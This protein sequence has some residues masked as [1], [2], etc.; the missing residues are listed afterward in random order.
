MEAQEDDFKLSVLQKLRGDPISGI[1]T[2]RRAEF[3]DQS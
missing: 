3:R 1:F 2:M